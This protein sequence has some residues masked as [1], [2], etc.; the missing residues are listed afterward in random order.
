M[1]SYRHSM[2]ETESPKQRTKLQQVKR[3]R[4]RKSFQD[5]GIPPIVSNDDLPATFGRKLG[6][7][8]LRIVNVLLIPESYYLTNQD[9]ADITGCKTADWAWKFRH[10]TRCQHI[11]NIFEGYRLRLARPQLVQVALV[12]AMQGSSRFWD[13]AAE[14]AGLWAPHLKIEHDIEMPQD[15][16]DAKYNAAIRLMTDSLKHL[17]GAE[18]PPGILQDA[19]TGDVSG[20]IPAD[21]DGRRQ[22]LPT[23]IRPASDSDSIASNAQVKT[24]SDIIATLSARK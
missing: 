5:Y 21:P 17:T 16:R 20:E 24:P 18:P 19:S 14:M 8:A 13:R 11:L 6:K 23:L 7:K 22:L 1:I 4:V 3:E 10:S 2:S 9:I 15:Q 12:R